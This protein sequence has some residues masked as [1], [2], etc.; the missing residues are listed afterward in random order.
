MDSLHLRPARPGDCDMLWEWRND[1]QTRRMERQQGFI[2]RAPYV[3][4]LHA[5]MASARRRLYVAELAGAGAGLCELAL[6]P[7]G[8]ADIGINLNPAFRGRRLATPLIRAAIA[9]AWPDLRFPRVMADIR[10]E[11]TPS[12]RAFARAGFVLARDEGAILRLMFSV[13]EERSS[14]SPVVSAWPGMG[15]RLQARVAPSP[16]S[17]R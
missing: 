3:D 15:R 2:P 5:I 1:P 16:P 10:A 7:D 6:R 9:A 4:W 14:F 8:A 17:G 12:R 13:D 11:N